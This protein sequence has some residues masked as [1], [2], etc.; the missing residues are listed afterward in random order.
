MRA[1]R[2]LDPKQ[3]DCFFQAVT[4]G[5]IRTAAERLGLEPSSVSRQIT[6]LEQSLAIG[7]VE[8]GRLGV[9]TTEAGD[10]LMAYVRNQTTELES[11]LSVLDDIR[12]MRRGSLSIAVGEGF[13]GDLLETALRLFCDEHPAIHLELETGGS[14]AVVARV[15]SDSAHL[16]LAYNPGAD[17]N[18]HSF[19]SRRQ[20]MMLLA[21]PQ[22][23]AAALPEPVS[24]AALSTFPCALLSHGFGV[25]ESLKVAEDEDGI[26]LRAGVHTNSIAVLKNYVRSCLG[27]TL[28]PAFVVVRELKDGVMI[29]KPLE[30]KALS[31]GEAHLLGRHGRRLPVTGSVLVNYLKRH[32]GVFHPPAA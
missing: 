3:M 7:L 20:P 6:Q 19:A 29:A 11:L 18:L 27:V 26:R 4:T 13:V 30:D 23:P 8:R 16:G 24:L 12:G 14:E 25:R 15:L 5:K 10:A 17:R 32:M 21:A 22:H 9:K 2:G 1:R 28:L 31:S